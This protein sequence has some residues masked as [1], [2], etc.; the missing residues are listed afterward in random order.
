MSKTIYPIWVFAAVAAAI[1]LGAYLA[2]QFHDDAG[3]IV[4]LGGSM[5]WTAFV[6]R[7]GAVQRGRNG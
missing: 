3:I 7:K 6:A 1:A 4:A 2:S 5:I